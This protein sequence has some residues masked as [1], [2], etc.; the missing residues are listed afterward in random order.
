MIR[1]WRCLALATM[2]FASLACARRK[3]GAADAGGVV[4]DGA[5]VGSSPETGPPPP[6]PVPTLA[7]PE[8]ARKPAGARCPGAEVAI[9]LQ[10]G[11]EACVIE[12][13]GHAGCPAGWACDGDGLLATNGRPGNP[14]QFCRIA[15]R[16][17]AADAGPLLTALPALVD[18]GG[19]GPPARRLDVKQ[20]NGQCPGGYRTCGALCRM[21][22]G[23]NSDCGLA[24]ASCQGGF[25]LGPGVQPCAK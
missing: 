20:V 3:P 19:S 17:K 10:P 6:A 1:T 25:C 7:N 21:T 8:P 9:V 4:E 14:I 23:K 2:V 13:K 18:A 12:C 16:V 11:E 5:A 24:T 15:S 22:C